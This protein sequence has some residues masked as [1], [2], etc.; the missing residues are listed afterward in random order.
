MLNEFRVGQ[1]KV[2]LAILNGTATA[3]EIKSERDGLSRLKRQLDA[4]QLVFP[5]R[6]VIAGENH[7]DGVLQATDSDVGV[8]MLSDRYQ[9]ST[10]REAADR[11]DL[12]QL[13]SI[14]DT[15]RID[16]AIKI[17]N[18]R[19]IEVPVVPN[20]RIRRELLEIFAGFAVEEIYPTFVRVVKESRTLAP[21]GD[22]L[23]DMPRSLHAATLTV[24]VKP[25]EHK[26]LLA[27]INSTFVD[28][29]GWA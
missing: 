3:Y 2:D 11:L 20:T 22:L 27:A 28:A 18:D 7:V 23:S 15:L 8:L 6:Y 17:L 1:C 14:F 10:I 25:V 13:S 5:R 21:L 24:R 26:N 4:Y 9:I 19:N 12:V 29:L 16:E